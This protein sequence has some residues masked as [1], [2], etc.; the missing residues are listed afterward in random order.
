[1]NSPEFHWLHFECP[2]PEV[3]IILA[4]SK[5]VSTMD[6]LLTVTREVEVFGFMVCSELWTCLYQQYKKRAANT[7]GPCISEN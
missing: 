5:K 2:T 6:S 7:I 4:K 1:M 3:Q